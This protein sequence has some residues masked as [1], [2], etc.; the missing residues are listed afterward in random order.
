MTKNHLEVQLLGKP[1][2][3]WQGR[4]LT[5][6]PPKQ[7][8]L[9]YYL[10]ARGEAVSRHELEELL[11]SHG[12]GYSV[13]QALYQL[14]LL[15]GADCWL[16]ADR[17]VAV[18]AITDLIAFEAAIKRMHH[19]EA[20]DVWMNARPAE[21]RTALL[22]SFEVDQAPG[23]TSWLEV[24][25]ARI[26]M[27]FLETLECR[28]LELEQ[29]DALNEALVVVQM[30]LREDRLN[31]S[32]YRMAMRLC[33]RKGQPEMANFYFER[34]RRALL[35]ELGTQPLEETLALA[36]DPRVVGVYTPSGMVGV[37]TQSLS[38][39]QMLEK[40]PD[41]RGRRGQRYP[42]PALLGLVL[43]ALLSGKHSMRD[44]V[45]FGQ[46]HPNLLRQLGFHHLTPP[47]RSA[48]SEVL[49]NLNQAR[50]REALNSTMPL[51]G[52]AEFEGYTSQTST[53]SILETW[54]LETRHSLVS[55]S[56]LSQLSEWLMRLGWPGLL[57]QAAL[58]AISTLT[59]CFDTAFGLRLG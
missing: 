41:P 12:S 44:I 16:H 21:G 54:A 26:E 37:D 52:T 40:L 13:R 59:E 46:T 55:G 22:W 57:G 50:L 18:E 24:E 32:A 11:W 42:L 31:E 20:L 33:Y 9:I 38:L 10:A 8:A 2:L 45:R 30:L 7:R 15:P 49:R 47:G 25:R 58:M 5:S 28:A 27:L 19:R 23:F 3:R 17:N 53:L 1:E 39:R 51:S 29:E 48:L 34:C 36:H 35:E 14:R 4:V 56:E 43:A 6:V